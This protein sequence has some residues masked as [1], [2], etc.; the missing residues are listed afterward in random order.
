M[1]NFKKLL[2]SAL[3]VSIL[4]FAS[5]TKDKTD[6][7][8]HFTF[9]VGTKA[10]DFGTTTEGFANTGGTYTIKASQHDTVYALVVI[11]SLAVGKYTNVSNKSNSNITLVLEDEMYSTRYGAS[12]TFTIEITSVTDTYVEGTFTSKVGTFSTGMGLES[13]YADV[14]GKF[15]YKK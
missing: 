11:P 14:T 8:N 13:V 10:Y 7:D 15:G 4:V 6:P 1:K 9:T 3:A 12:S 2:L 5:C